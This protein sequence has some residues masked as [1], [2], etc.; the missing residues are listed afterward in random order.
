MSTKKSKKQDETKTDYLLM[1]GIIGFFVVMIDD[2]SGTPYSGKIIAKERNYYIIE[3]FKP[4][5][6]EFELSGIIILKDIKELLDNNYNVL[7]DRYVESNM[8]H[9]GGK[10]TT[11]E[12]RIAMYK[13]LEN[14][15]YVLLELPRPDLT[16]FSYMPYQYAEELKKNREEEPDQHE[17]DE[18]HLLNAENAYLEL[19][20]LYK[21]NR[22]NCVSNGNIRTI[23]DIHEEVY[24]VVKKK[25]L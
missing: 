20:S 8:G 12:A 2:I 10:I 15:E 16:V 19:A 13:W 4:F 6:K 14:L 9:Q 1:N 24:S 23:D 7:V 22:V 3:F 21:F 11:T 25:I 5:I 18:E 17:A